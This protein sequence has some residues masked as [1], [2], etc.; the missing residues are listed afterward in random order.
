[1]IN[2]FIIYIFVLFLITTFAKV[3]VKNSKAK[4]KPIPKLNLNTDH[5]PTLTEILNDLNLVT[6]VPNFVKMGV[7]ETKHLIQ[8]KSMDFRIMEFDW[9][10][11]TSDDINRLKV[12]IAT[13]LE[14]ATVIEDIRM[15][16]LNE[17]R[18]LK[19]G[20]I[21][22]QNSVQ[23]FEYLTASFGGSPPLGLFPIH[24]NSIENLNLCDLIPNLDL[25]G[26]VLIIKRGNC[27]FL[28]KALNAWK[29]N[30]S[31]LIIVNNEDHLDSPS[32]GLGVDKS[33]TDSIVKQLEHFPIIAVSNTSFIKF[34]IAMKY[35]SPNAMI[36]IVP[37]KCG[38]G[39]VCLPVTQEEKLLI[40]EITW[41]TLHFIENNLNHSYQFL[42]STFG[43]SLPGNNR[44]EY[45]LLLSN[46]ID[47]CET[48]QNDYQENSIFVATRGNC[49]FDVKVL[50]AQNRGAM[51]L[52]IIDIEDNAL[53]RIGGQNPISGYV[54]IPSILVTKICGDEIFH[55]FNNNLNT[56]VSIEIGVGDSVS[57]A[58]IDVAYTKFL[59]NTNDRLMQLQGMIQ[60]YSHQN[61][62]E[63]VDWLKRQQTKTYENITNVNEQQQCIGTA[64]N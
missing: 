37:L 10:T 16:E 52:I 35:S 29:L 11:I 55:R 33:I 2:N 59:N 34:E 43:S 22:L 21:Y 38:H 32:S 61:H 17:R 14:E 19:Y 24:I 25:T 41:G 39:G 4:P 62:H 58:W 48:L 12:R 54:G 28:T 45:P 42:T 6:Y 23:S 26:K 27:T 47:G 46:P 13:L 5:L 7:T 15:P 60:L 50:N 3:Q 49:N 40:S 30:A 57:D 64:L 53:Q 31:V 36:T 20:R 44:Q 56:N 1:M 63:I 51:L 18:H 8:L 9:K